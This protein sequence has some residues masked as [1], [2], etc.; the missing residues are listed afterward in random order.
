MDERKIIYRNEAKQ[1]GLIRYFPGRTCDRGHTE[2]Y[3]TSTG[4]C[5][6]CARLITNER[7]VRLADGANGVGIDNKTFSRA[8]ARKL[9]KKF[10]YTGQP[11]PHGHICVR[12]TISK[13]CHFCSIEK[14]RKA[15]ER[16]GMTVAQESNPDPLSGS[17]PPRANKKPR[18]IRGRCQSGS[19]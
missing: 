1:R 3:Y 12:Y 10:Y 14:V 2:E 17:M 5:V 7:R 18:L 6:E 15:P 19:I 11:C 9:G 8:E 4:N 13:A 16:K